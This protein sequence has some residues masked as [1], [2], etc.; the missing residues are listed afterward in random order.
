MV[1]SGLTPTFSV[2]RTFT[3]I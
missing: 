3:D 2:V 1:V